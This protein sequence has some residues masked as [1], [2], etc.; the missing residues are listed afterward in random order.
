MTRRACGCP[1]VPARTVTDE[2]AHAAF[3]ALVV[4]QGGPSGEV[5]TGTTRGTRVTTVGVGTARQYGGGDPD[6][7]GEVRAW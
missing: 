7:R 1:V 6:D 4:E 5:R 3:H 2:A